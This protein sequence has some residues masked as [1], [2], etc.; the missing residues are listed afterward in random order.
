M[1]AC[2]NVGP[3][4]ASKIETTRSLLLEAVN[5]APSFGETGDAGIW[6]S[7][8]APMNVVN[9]A[10]HSVIVSFRIGHLR[11]VGS[12]NIRSP[13]SFGTLRRK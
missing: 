1:S 8:H 12:L 11:L 10:I 3:S 6:W 9:N 13:V 2:V 4:H 7:A 5:D